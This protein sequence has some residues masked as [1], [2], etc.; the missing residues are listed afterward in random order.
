MRTI[1]GPG[2]FLAQFAHDTA[3]HN[4]LMSMAEW[5][6]GYGYKA[7]QIPTWDRLLF[8]LDRAYDSATYCDEIKGGLADRGIVISELSTHFQGQMVSVHPAYDLMFDG[9]VAPDLRQNPEKR[10]HWAME[11]VKKAAVVSRRL[12]LTESVSF[13]GSLAWPYFY[14][15]PQRPDGLIEECFAEQGRR[16]RPILDVYEENGVDL[17]YEIHPSEDV[18]DG[19]TFEMFLA[20][21]GNHAR[22]HI[23]YDASHFIK[24]CMDYLGFI[25]VYHE[26]IRMFHVKDAEFNPT[27]R[28]GVYGGYKGWLE[29]A[30]RDRSLG[31]GQVD[32][33]GVFSR[34]TQ[35]GFKGWAVYEWECCLQHPEA[36]ARDGA[37]FIADQIIEATDRVFDDFARTGADTATNRALLGLG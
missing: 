23:N 19:D 37:R 32:F 21:V 10:R 24:Q 36:A 9:Q 25:D 14:P 4:S 34:L 16:W 3:P 15:Y 20:A 6:A 2:L 26:R 5:A 28:Q 35:Y 17:C 8:D 29:R 7:V 13:T 1:K 12:G 22:C 27:A 11:Q 31:H 33:K 30:G 18:F